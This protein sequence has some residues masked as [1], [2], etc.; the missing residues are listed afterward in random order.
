MLSVVLVDD[1]HL[2]R[3]CLRMCLGT[4]PDVTV[5]GEASNGE[6]AIDLAARLTPD[7]LVL[8]VSLP[9]LTGPE[10]AVA[11]RK[12]SPLTRILALSMHS[13]REF[14][15]SM[16]RAGAQGYVLKASAYDEL[17]E[18]ISVV[19]AGG[20]YVSPALGGHILLDVAQGR[21]ADGLAPLTPRERDVLRLLAR[22]L[23][24][25]EAAWELGLSDKTVHAVRSRLQRKTGLRSTAE[26]TRYAMRTGLTS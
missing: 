22:G 18:A 19:G 24:T 1:H 10:V 23:S 6:A 21:G 25:K 4:S 26:L 13:E 15:M 14:V 12:Q 2:V 11:V 3:Q 16:F 17:V 20:S 9:G 7:V 8:D 5:S